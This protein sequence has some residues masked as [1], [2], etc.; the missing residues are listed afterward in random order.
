MISSLDRPRRQALPR[1]AS[2]TLLLA[3]LPPLATALLALSYFFAGTIVGAYSDLTLARARIVLNDARDSVEY[4]LSYGFGTEQLAS[5]ERI[6]NE[7]VDADPEIDAITL[8]TPEGRVL[9]ASGPLAS[10]TDRVPSTSAA[11]GPGD[12]EG[13]P[14]EVEAPVRNAHDLR[15]GTLRMMVTDHD[16]HGHARAA[17][18]NLAVLG[19]LVIVGATGLTHGLV[20]LWANLPGRARRR[21]MDLV[22][23]LLLGSVIA[24]GSVLVFTLLVYRDYDNHARILAGERARTVATMVARPVL[25]GLR[26]GVPLER[27]VDAGSF[28]ESYRKNV[29]EIHGIAITNS[30][31]ERIHDAG[32]KTSVPGLVMHSLPIATDTTAGSHAAGRIVV[33]VDPALRPAGAKLSDF[34]ADAI[35]AAILVWQ[36]VAFPYYLMSRRRERLAA[37][38][39]VAHSTR[40]AGAS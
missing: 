28:L 6:L 27:L 30:I 9:A 33:H 39:V 29:P 26:H 2:F 34:M 25:K 22:P 21:Q 17:V 31:G 8:T 5:I 35:V 10:H 24:I 32:R 16:V 3:V 12:H 36:G 7:Y 18:E 19:L 38:S 37:S 4:G 20:R 15:I 1:R 14:H 11:A 13:G 23:G 40:A